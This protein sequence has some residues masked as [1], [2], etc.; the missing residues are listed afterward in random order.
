MDVSGTSQTAGSSANAGSRAGESAATLAGDFDQFLNLLTTQLKYQDPTDPVDT[1]EFTAQLVQFTQ[2]EQLV[3]SNSNLET[4]IELQRNSQIADSANY[5]GKTIIADGHTAPL[6]DGKAS[7]NY[8]LSADAEEVKIAIIDKGGNIVYT[9]NG[10]TGM[11]S[12][13]FIWDGRSNE[14]VPLPEGPYR[15]AITATDAADEVVDATSTISGRVDGVEITDGTLTLSVGGVN[16]SMEQ[17][18]G[19]HATPTAAPNNSTANNTAG[20]NTAGD[21]TDTGAGSDTTT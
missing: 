6:Q 2:A 16:V 13:E 20:D 12:H 10:D 8:T 1:K 15:I 18:I 3:H 9:G 5:I 17:V 14:G 19:V 7:Y 11:G 21:N 4:M